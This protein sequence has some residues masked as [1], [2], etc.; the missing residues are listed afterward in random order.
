MQSCYQGAKVFN[1]LSPDI[2]DEEKLSVFKRRI[3]KLGLQSVY[4]TVFDYGVQVLKLP[5]LM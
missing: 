1:L 5:C 2:R 4:N 3:K